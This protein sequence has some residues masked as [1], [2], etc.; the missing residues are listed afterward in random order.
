MAT[1]ILTDV[2]G[3]R[4]YLSALPDREFEAVAVERTRIW[5]AIAAVSPASPYDVL[6]DL[7]MLCRDEQQRRIDVLKA[8]IANLQALIEREK[9]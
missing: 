8:Q 3:E 4:A 7:T 5:A 6:E 1:R 9:P 2:E